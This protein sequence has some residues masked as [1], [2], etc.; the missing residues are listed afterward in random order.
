MITRF[1]KLHALIGF[2]RRGLPGRSLSFMMAVI[3]IDVLSQ[4]CQI[5]AWFTFRIFSFT[6]KTAALIPLC[7]NDPLI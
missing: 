6:L 3:L 5:H 4:N 7:K 1:S 2:L